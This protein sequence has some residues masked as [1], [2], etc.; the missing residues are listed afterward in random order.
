MIVK[1]T[2]KEIGFIWKKKMATKNHV[3]KYKYITVGKKSSP[4]KVYA[5][6]LADCTHFIPHH[7][8]RLVV[9]KKSICWE[10][11]KEMIITPDI[12]RKKTVKPRCFK[13]RGKDNPLLGKNKS[14]TT[15]KEPTQFNDIVD[16]L[17]K[18]RGGM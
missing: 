13:C 16:S 12:F 6:T 7:Q 15:E 18:M 14:V 3:H 10:C 2:V 11:G 8:E 9:G 17:L 4:H 1:L 5:C